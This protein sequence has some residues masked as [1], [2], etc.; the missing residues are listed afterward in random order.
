MIIFLVNINGIYLIKNKSIINS[1]ETG[2]LVDSNYIINILKNNVKKDY[3][4]IT[5]C[6]SDNILKY[7]SKI[8]D[9]PLN[10]VSTFDKNMIQNNNYRGYIVGNLQH[11][12]TVDNILNNLNIKKDNSY[13]KKFKELDKSIIYFFEIY[14]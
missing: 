5:K 1:T 3:I 11:N 8:Y 10:I 4:I 9:I 7:Y 12:Q 2:V 14:N 6:P 13:V